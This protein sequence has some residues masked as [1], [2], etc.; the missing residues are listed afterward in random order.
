MLKITEDYEEWCSDCFNMEKIGRGHERCANH[1]GHPMIKSR[2]CPIESRA[3]SI[4][5]RKSNKD[6]EGYQPSGDTLD[7][8]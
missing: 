6:G 8:F 4:V 7:N 2:G 1:C 5:K 3:V